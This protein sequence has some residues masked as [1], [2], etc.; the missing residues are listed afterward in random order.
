MKLHKWIFAAAGI[1]LFSGIVFYCIWPEIRDN[2]WGFVSAKTAESDLQECAGILQ[3]Y[4]P[5][6]RDGLPGK[7]KEIYDEILEE[8]QGK[9]L[10]SFRRETE[11]LQKLTRSLDDAHTGIA[12]QGEHAKYLDRIR[13][14]EAEGVEFEYRDGTVYLI[15]DQKSYEVTAINRKTVKEVLENCRLYEEHENEYGIRKTIRTLNNLGHLVWIDLAETTDQA[16]T[17]EYRDGEEI[18]TESF[19]F[20]KKEQEETEKE[21]WSWEINQEENYA[22]LTLNQCRANDAFS[23]AM[24]KFFAELCTSGVENLAIDVRQNPGGDVPDRVLFPYFGVME[25]NSVGRYLEAGEYGMHKRKILGELPDTIFRG[26]VYVLT[27]CNTFSAAMSLSVVCSING[28]AKVIGEPSSQNVNSY[29]GIK[30]ATFGSGKFVMQVSKEYDYIAPVP[31]NIQPVDIPC[32][33]RDAWEVF[34]KEIGAG[35]SG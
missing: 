12:V 18:R 30:I 32:D 35:E 26:N 9:V 7:T 20:S 1:L 14:Q 21:P 17:V 3:D 19:S 16:V 24:K 22:V 4:H 6:C 29:T 10:V 2:C 8:Y 25:Y 11:N 5:L 34:K 15:L 33:P 31:G 27:S 13:E 23:K 28:V